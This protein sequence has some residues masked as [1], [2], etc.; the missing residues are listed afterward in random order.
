MVWMGKA[1]H[2]WH[3]TQYASLIQTNAENMFYYNF[4]EKYMLQHELSS[5]VLTPT[6]KV[7]LKFFF[8]MYLYSKL[9]TW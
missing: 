3:V 8:Q 9:N 6:L 4:S 1:N 7:S 2:Q 5:N